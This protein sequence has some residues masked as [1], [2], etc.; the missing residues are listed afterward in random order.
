MIIG[1]Y[2][3]RER[4]AKATELFVQYYT[5]LVGYKIQKI[6]SVNLFNLEE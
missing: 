6:K 3:F 1:K 4:K 2:G 5:K